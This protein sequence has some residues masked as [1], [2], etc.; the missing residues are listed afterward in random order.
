MADD[1]RTKD[2][3]PIAGGPAVFDRE[4]YGG[5]TPGRQGYSSVAL[6]DVDAMDDQQDDVMWVPRRSASCLA[7]LPVPRAPLTLPWPPFTSCRA[8]R[9]I[10]GARAAFSDLPDPTEDDSLQGMGF[11][12]P[13]TIFEREDDYRRRRL[14]RVISPDRNDAFAMG[15][16]TPDA[17]VRTYAD[18]MREQQ[19]QR[20]TDNTMRNIADKK[21]KEAEAVAAGTALPSTTAPA[22]PAAGPADGKRRNRWDTASGDG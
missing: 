14:Q 5:A 10:A 18:I 1:Q 20:E 9:G 19:L 21:K 7:L 11:Q 13:A 15:D 2:G 12:K 17:R 8:P 3:V 4:L 22:A 6:D 16:K